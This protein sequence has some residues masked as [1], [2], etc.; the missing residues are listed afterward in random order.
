VSDSGFVPPETLVES[1]RRT[2]N[3]EFFERDESDA[4][5]HTE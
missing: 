1:L 3:Y 2:I 4:V 5:F